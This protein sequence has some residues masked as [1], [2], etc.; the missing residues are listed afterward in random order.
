MAFFSRTRATPPR[1]AAEQ[2]SAGL[3][4]LLVAAEQVAA[5]VAQ[6]THGRRRVGQ[7]EAFWQFRPYFPGDTANRIDWRQTARRDGARGAGVYVRDL[8]WEAAQSV[9]LWHDRSPSM[10]WRSTPALPLKGDRAM[11]LMLALGM[12]LA[13]GGERIGLLGGAERPSP[14]RLGLDRLIRQVMGDA[15]E[16]GAGLP[17]VQALPRRAQIVLIGDF[18]GPIEET[19]AL[20]GRYLARE[21]AGQLVQI[22]DP[23]EE[24]PPYAGR[25]R[26]EGT[27]RE[28][29]ALIS[30]A[31]DIRAAY[32]LRLD[33]HRAALRQITRA[34]GWGFIAHRTDHPPAASLLA[35]WAALS[36]QG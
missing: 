16:D 21:C 17:P 6:G 25:V 23:A 35:L 30:R 5:T 32:R 24:D 10:A 18:L 28:P 9:F 22:L 26:F 31:E 2:L 15:N 1:Q 11:V 13:R 29:A 19:R 12:L 4:A 7:G 20:L 34:A 33:G 14:G 27:E 8:E 36:G 3:P